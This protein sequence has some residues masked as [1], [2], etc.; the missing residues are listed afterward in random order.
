MA[1]AVNTD[2]E[3][4]GPV[5]PFTEQEPFLWK[6]HMYYNFAAGVGSGKTAT[7]VI[8]DA[9]N[10][11]VWNPGYMG[12]IV[13]PTTQMIKNAI[14]PKMQEFGIY[15]RWEYYG[16]SA[17]L[18]GF[19][20]PQGSRVVV[21]SADNERHVERAAGLDLAWWH[22]DEARDVPERMYEI[23]QQRLRVG[24]YRNGYTT[25]TPRK[26]HFED[27]CFRDVPDESE[28]YGMANIYN[29]DDRLT[30]T[31]VTPD[32]NPY[33][34]DDYEDRLMADLP[35]SIAAQEVKG[36]FVEVSG[37]VYSRDTFG[38]IDPA[39]IKDGY[40][41]NYVLGV[42]PAATADHQKAE[43]RDSDYWAVTLAAVHRPGNEIFAVDQ[44]R[45]RGMT[46]SE[47]AEWIAQIAKSAGASVLVESNQAQRWLGQELAD[48]NLKVRQVQTTKNKEDK[49]IGM[50]IPLENDV[51]QFVNHETDSK[52]GYDPRWQPLIQEALAFPEGSHDDLM[53]S[54]NIILENTSIHHNSVLSADPYG[55]GEDDE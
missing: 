42:D 24:N 7:G 53:D 43:R 38:F 16:P 51:V 5:E 23:L 12:A 39:D 30:I 31:G 4:S 32:C 49:L 18:P 47:G 3:D 27:W 17:E 8:R 1:T 15:D 36:E 21:L 50:S 44:K 37:G 48:Y 19:H 10:A 46:L 25:S 9:L 29:G 41:L 22:I 34:P 6:S 28:S 20:T 26:N 40:P 13:A 55:R 14:V 33:V 11:E 54:L 35:D 52:L 45:Q 2:T